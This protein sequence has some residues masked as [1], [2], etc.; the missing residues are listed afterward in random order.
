MDFVRTLRLDAPEFLLAVL[1]QRFP[2]IPFGRM[3][4]KAAGDPKTRSGRVDEET[5]MIED[6]QSASGAPLADMP[7]EQ[8]AVVR[9]AAADRNAVRRWASVPE[10]GVLDMI[11]SE[12]PEINKNGLSMVQRKALKQAIMDL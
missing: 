7:A 4:S 5:L 3:L 1:E 12:R 11:R 9:E 6:L 10:M 2:Q 8:F